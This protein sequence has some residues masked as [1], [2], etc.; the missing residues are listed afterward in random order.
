MTDPLTRLTD[1]FQSAYGAEPA[2]IARAPG[3]VN[4]LGEHV[5][6]NDG[7]VMPIAI[8]RAAYVAARHVK[9]A[10]VTVH[11]LD[12]RDQTTFTLSQLEAK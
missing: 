6:Y 8:D 10:H 4:L 3:R 1:A 2:F 11:A 5:D 7:W 12:V 9:S